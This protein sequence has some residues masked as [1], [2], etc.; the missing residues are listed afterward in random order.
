MLRYP[1]LKGLWCRL[2]KCV[3]DV[4]ESIKKFFVYKELKHVY[5]K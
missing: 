1:S 4:D 2:W 5:K 3:F